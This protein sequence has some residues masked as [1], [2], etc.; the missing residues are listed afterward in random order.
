[1][2]KE[3]SFSKKDCPFCEGTTGY[4]NREK[5]IDNECKHSF[6]VSEYFATLSAIK[7]LE[8]DLRRNRKIAKKMKLIL[9][10]NSTNGGNYA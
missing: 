2:K 3:F 1:M 10:V 9:D 8:A 5:G 7:D 6:S 4:D